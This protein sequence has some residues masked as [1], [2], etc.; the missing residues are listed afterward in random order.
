MGPD[1]NTTLKDSAYSRPNQITI[2][3]YCLILLTL[4]NVST[5]NDSLHILQVCTD[6]FRI[7]Q[8]KQLHHRY[9]KCMLYK[10]SICSDLNSTGSGDSSVVK[11]P[12]HDLRVQSSISGRSSGKFSSPHSFCADSFQYSLH[13]RVTTVAHTKSCLFCQKCRWQ[14]T[15]KHTYTLPVWL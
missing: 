6:T 7:T 5:F 3:L 14:V 10:L 13:P 11:C 8:N 9:K 1:T 2:R 12:I 15:A 4:C